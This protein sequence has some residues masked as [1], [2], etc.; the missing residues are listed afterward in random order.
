MQESTGL[1]SQ[2]ARLLN[3]CGCQEIQTKA[4]AVEYR[5]GTPRGETFYQD[6]KL[7]FK[8]SRPFIEKWGCVTEDYENIYRQA[9]KEI[10]QPDFLVVG[11]I[12]TVWGYKP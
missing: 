5:A 4:Y 1:T 3:E 10:R 9:L 11:N 12:L 6:V 2:L 8:T 7:L